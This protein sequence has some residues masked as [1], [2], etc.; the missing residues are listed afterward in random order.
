MESAAFQEQA[1]P[2]VAPILGISADW[3]IFSLVLSIWIAIFVLFGRGQRSRRRQQNRELANKII[4]GMAS[5]VQ[6]TPAEARSFPG[7]RHHE[8][9]QRSSEFERLGF[10]QSGDFTFS[11]NGEAE[12]RGFFRLFYHPFEHCFAEVGLTRK[13]LKDEN[14]A[15]LLG[16]T[17][18]LEPG[19]AIGTATAR[20]SITGYLW[21]LPKV[22]EIKRPGASPEEL[23]NRHL[24]LRRRV[25]QDL[26]LGVTE[27]SSVQNRFTRGDNTMRLRKEALLNRDIIGD[28]R[29]AKRIQE[30]G[31][32]EWLGDYPQVAARRAK[33]KKLRNIPD[34]F[35]VYTAP[36]KDALEALNNSTDS[37]EGEISE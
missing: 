17:S 6:R 35:S 12:I 1:A 26:R 15:F 31:P 14:E 10:T 19:W 34:T 27:D 29:E 23:F 18:S 2:L 25:I 5:S 11:F 28:F 22:L 13:S 8:L 9:L 37:S 16:V 36:Q 24:Q 4:A 7:I 20:P 30:Q 33:G 32:W 3:I 21:R